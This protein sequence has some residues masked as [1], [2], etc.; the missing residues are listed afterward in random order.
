MN[1]FDT[2]GKT[3]AD[4]RQ[5]D[6]RILALLVKYLGLSD[7]ATVAD[8]GAGTG[9]YSNA[10]A[11]TGFRVLAIEPSPIMLHHSRNHPRVEWRE[12][13][14]ENVP[15]PDGSVNGVVSTLAVCHFSNVQ[16]ALAEMARITDSGTVVIFTF[17]NGLGR[18]TW[19]YEY[20]PFFWDAFD[21]YPR[22]EKL[23]RMLAAV[24]GRETDVVPFTLPKDLRDNFAAAAWQKPERYLEERY[25]AN[26][27]SFQKA[28]P[29]T[30]DQ[31]IAR[32]AEDLASGAWEKRHGA[33]LDLDE[34]DAGYRFVCTRGKKTRFL[35]SSRNNAS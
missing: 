14:A 5:A 15:L 9:N 33:V 6:E 18:D 1:L 11:E 26:I 12:G 27:S 29:G 8:I 19:M 32:L 2:I 20:F 17:D 13:D 34:L 4:T 25:R 31:G 22:P 30:V 35:E 23:A 28:D 10:L 24:T 16:K 21:H 3:Y 7:G